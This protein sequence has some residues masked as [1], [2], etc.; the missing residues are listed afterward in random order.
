M[1]T[2][3]I[4][5][6]ESLQLIAEMIQ[7]SKRRYQLDEGKPFLIWGYTALATAAIV[8]LLLR[9]TLSP[10]SNLGWLLI[11]FVG[12]GLTK[13][14][15]S[16]PSTGYAKTYTDTMLARFWTFAGALAWVMTLCCAILH[17]LG[18]PAAWKAMMV[19]GLLIIGLGHVVSG[20]IL[21]ERSIV[22]GG[23]IATLAGTLLLCIVAAGLPIVASWFLPLYGLAFVACAIV[24]GHVL[25]AK[26]RR[27]HRSNSSAYA[28]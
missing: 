13:L 11:P 15:L 7:Q 18:Y 9:T 27:Q 3:T 20:I 1:D 16:P 10:W 28:A 26:A 4:N 2:H 19:Y 12:T 8:W 25:N 5:Q 22:V 17:Y 24:P 6:Q 23:S 21:S 14:L